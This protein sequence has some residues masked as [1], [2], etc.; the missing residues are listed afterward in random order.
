MLNHAASHKKLQLQ[1]FASEHRF[2]LLLLYYKDTGVLRAAKNL[3]LQASILVSYMVCH[4]DAA[5]I[6]VCRVRPSI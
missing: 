1:S 3:T 5:N 4:S 2:L 6:M